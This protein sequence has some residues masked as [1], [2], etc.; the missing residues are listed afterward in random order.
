DHL[1]VNGLRSKFWEPDDSVIASARA[2]LSPWAGHQPLMPVFSSGQWAGQ[3]PDLYAALGSVDLRHL[4]G[5]GI[6]GHP[7]GIAAGMA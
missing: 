3:A 2:C 5:G 4:A 7:D 1:H 6:I